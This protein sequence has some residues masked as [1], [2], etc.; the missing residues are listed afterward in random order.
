MSV[1]YQVNK[2]SFPAA[3]LQFPTTA[4]VCAKQRCR[5]LK[6][7]KEKKRRRANL[8]NGKQG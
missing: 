3:F 2:Y 6:E 4:G 7:R 5:D 8:S 1:F